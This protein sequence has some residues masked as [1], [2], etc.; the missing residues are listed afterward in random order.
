MTTNST[1]PPLPNPFTPLAFLPR[2]VADKFEVSIY[3]FVACLSVSI[4][5]RI[6]RGIRVY[7]F[8]LSTSNSKAYMI[9]WVMTVREEINIFRSRPVRP[10][11]IAY[12]A[13]R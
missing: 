8:W 4:H 10:V 7:V 9:E 11:T 13:S 1:L 3:V 6:P 5:L 12:F 2:D